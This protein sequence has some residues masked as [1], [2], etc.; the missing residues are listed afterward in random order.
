MVAFVT[1][2]AAD[3]WTFAKQGCTAEMKKYPDMTL[4]FKE[5]GSGA[6]AEQTQIVND[7]LANGCKAIA[8][9]PV[10]PANETQLL[11]KAASEA[12][13]VTQDSDAP[14]SNRACYIGTDNHAAGLK[15][16]ALIKE[17]CPNGGKI[18]LFVGK[19]DAQNAKD[20]AQGIEDA[21]KGSNLTIVDTRTDDTDTTRAKAN[22][23]DALV[24][25][26]DLV[27]LVGLWN[28]NTPAIYGAM[29]DAGKLGKIKIVGFDDEADTL[30]GI[31]QGYIYGTVV[32][33]PYVFGEKVVD[34]FHDYVVGGKKDS[35]P[36][37]K[38]EY[39]DTE[40]IKQADVDA[41]K[42]KIAKLHG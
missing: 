38:T 28:Y 35:I 7:L 15:V 2:N 13:L 5:P 33:Q 22:A 40:V 9:S 18:M 3:Y 41:Y 34:L 16:G 39:I 25:D 24:K 21:L 27:C 8:I 36:A 20:R 6:S 12:L 17:A 1:N 11:N 14:N 4:Q 19:K 37:S 10:D 32:Q 26:P 30:N 23:S 29:K 31:K 42:A